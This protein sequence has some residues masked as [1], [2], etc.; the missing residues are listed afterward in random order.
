MPTTCS[1]NSL[2][3]TLATHEFHRSYSPPTKNARTTTTVQDMPTELIYLF[4]TDLCIP[5]VSTLRGGSNQT[6]TTYVDILSLIALRN[7]MITMSS[8]HTILAKEV[9]ANP[10]IVL[11]VYRATNM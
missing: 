9:Y 2:P 4:K 10:G 3:N 11:F 6:S 7:S 1:A 8:A 5:S